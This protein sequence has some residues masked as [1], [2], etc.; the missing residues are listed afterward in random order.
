MDEEKF[1]EQYRAGRLR[2]ESQKSKPEGFLENLSPSEKKARNEGFYEAKNELK[3]KA[4][5]EVRES[6]TSTSSESDDSYT[7]ESGGFDIFDTGICERKNVVPIT[8]ASA[9]GLLFLWLAWLGLTGTATF[10]LVWC[11]SLIAGICGILL[12]LPLAYFLVIC[13]IYLLAI[14]LGIA[15]IALVIY[16]LYLILKLV[17]VIFRYFA[18]NLY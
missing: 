12:L 14:V 17:A 2:A 6:L 15:A 3:Q 18:N 7:S 13:G 10:S 5:N 4:K 16:I 8:L 1:K 11:L 9:A